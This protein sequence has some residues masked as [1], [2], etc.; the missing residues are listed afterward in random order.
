MPDISDAVR[1]DIEVRLGRFLKAKDKYSHPTFIGS[2]GSAAIYKVDTDSGPRAIK[3]YDPKFLTGDHAKAEAR[4]LDLQRSLIGHDCSTLVKVFRVEEAE[5]TAFIEME[6]V[7]WPQLKRVLADVPD[8][9]VSGLVKQL[10]EAVVFLEKLD[11]AHRDVKPENIH[12]SEDFSQLKLID[13]GV[14]R[15]MSPRDEEG[16]DAT[17]HG[18]KRP[19]IA[20]A[21]YSSPE[22]LFRLDA[23]SPNLWKALNIYQV[24]AVLH[25]LINK[26]PLFDDEVNL[27]NRW[28]V[29]RAVLTKIPNFPD[30][31]PTRLVAQKALAIRCLTK[32][33]DTR[34]RIVSW[35][36][37]TFEA[38]T[39]GLSTLKSR[40]AKGKGL[41][42][43]QGAAAVDERLRFEREQ[44]A[45][46]FCEVVRTEL[47]AA[48]DRK[49]H[50][51]MVVNAS[52]GASGYEFELEIGPRVTVLASVRL[53]WFDDMNCNSAR[54]SIAAALSC[55]SSA[56][57]NPEPQVVAVATISESEET[58][59]LDVARCLADI[60]VRVL[61]LLE[62]TDD[63]TVLHGTDIGQL[64]LDTD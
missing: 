17:D 37:F 23:P 53:D 15:T 21:Q 40:L 56:A 44:F 36:D 10:V 45:K 5:G 8:E 12:V 30:A 42:G 38:S 61:D 31:D 34:L 22:Y 26:K 2:G 46:R 59:A 4:R 47:I 62:S 64:V 29:A 60:L 55:G 54:V 14:S 18:Q 32:D 11:I 41:A 43:S 49:V 9:K 24:G 3:V 25:D 52:G 48:C 1:E 58:I 35:S 51:T 39:D 7:P 63:V 27:D 50:V 33:V 6:F 13:L 57:P 19:F 28:L 20:T 16:N